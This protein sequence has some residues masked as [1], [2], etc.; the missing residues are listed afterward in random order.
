V[1]SIQIF[2]DSLNVINWAR[3]I[4][5]CHNILLLSLLEEVL[6]IFITFESF[7]IRHLYRNE[8]SKKIYSL[9]K[10]FKW[11]MGNG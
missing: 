11:A 9:K 6:R 8:T 7:Y 2:G 4:K 10:L 1:K 5:K 3:K